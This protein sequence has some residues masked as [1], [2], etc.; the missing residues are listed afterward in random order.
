MDH[1]AYFDRLYAD[2]SDPWHYETRWYEQRKRDICLGLLLK[3]T[4]R[5]AIELGCGNGVL[6]NH[7]AERC[8]ALTCLD[9]HAQAVL[10][11]RQRLQAF[12][13]VTVIQ[14]AIP[15]QL[16]AQSFDLIVVSEI[17]YYLSAPE[18]QA[19]IEWAKQH[20]AQD[21][22]LLCCHWR[23]PIAGFSL[24]GNIVHELL[25][26]HIPMPHYLNLNDADFIVDLWRNG[27]N[28]LDSLALDE[29]LL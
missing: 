26:Q 16:P 10:L 1:T 17:L 18:L 27:P 14:A 25:K 19:F 5:Q 8:E 28:H 12:E 11:A 23:Y 2:N 15:Q 3:P 20:L 22:T 4:Y 21:G 6:S 7:L 9:G 29:G 24:N 13:H